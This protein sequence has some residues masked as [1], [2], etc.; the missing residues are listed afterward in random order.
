MKCEIKGDIARTK[1]KTTPSEAKRRGA[2]EMPSHQRITAFKITYFLGSVDEMKN[3][4]NWGTRMHRENDVRPK[5]ETTVCRSR[6]SYKGFDVVRDVSK[7]LLFKFFDSD[8]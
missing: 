2:D 4:S 1:N 3:T 8:F 5:L 7:D 6:S